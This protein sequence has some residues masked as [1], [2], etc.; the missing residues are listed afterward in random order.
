[1]MDVRIEALADILKKHVLDVLNQAKAGEYLDGV[2]IVLIAD[3]DGAKSKI[4]MPMTER[5]KKPSRISPELSEKIQK[6]K[7][8]L[9]GNL[10]ALNVMILLAR[11]REELHKLKLSSLEAT[12]QAVVRIELDNLKTELTRKLLEAK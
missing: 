6:V 2:K 8:T 10:D 5:V 11:L 7:K 9:K 1:M 3:K 4:A 12:K